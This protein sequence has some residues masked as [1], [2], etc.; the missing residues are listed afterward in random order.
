MN[1]KSQFII[2]LIFFIIFRKIYSVPEIDDN[3]KKQIY[4]FFMNNGLVEVLNDLDFTK[5]F[6]FQNL[7]DISKLERNMPNYN[8]TDCLNMIKENNN[9][10]K[11]LSDIYIIIIELNDQKYANGQFNLFTKPINTTIFKFFTKNFHIEGF[12]DYS[13][14]NNMEIKVSKKVETSKIDYQDIKDIEQKYNISV[15][16]NESNFIDYCSPLSINNKD[17]TVYDRQMLIFKNVKPCDDGCTFLNFNYTT[18]YST[19]LCKIYDEEKDINLLNGIYEK[20]KDNE[21]IQKL[22]QLLDKGNW[23]YFKCFKQAFKTNTKEKHNWIKYISYIPIIIVIILHILSVKKLF[24]DENN[25]SKKEETTNKNLINSSNN[26]NKV[27]TISINN[28]SDNSDRSETASANS[29]KTKLANLSIIDLSGD[30]NDDNEENNNN[31]NNNTTD[32]NINNN[33]NNINNNINKKKVK[34]SLIDAPTKTIR[35]LDSKSNFTKKKSSHNNFT[36]S[37]NIKNNN[38]DEKKKKSN[39]FHKIE[40]YKSNNNGT[41]KTNNKDLKEMCF[42]IIYI[43]TSINLKQDLLSLYSALIIYILSIH[44]FIFYNAFLFSDKTISARYYLKRKH[45]IKY[46]LI[47]EFDRI[48]LVFLICKIINKIFIFLLNASNESLSFVNKIENEMNYKNEQEIIIVN[49]KEITN[50]NIAEIR[51]KSPN[52]NE[53][54]EIINS[55]IKSYKFKIFAIQAFIIFIQII[56]AYFFMIFGN[57]NPNVQ[58]SLLWSSLTSFGV[59]ILFNLFFYGIKANVKECSIKENNYFLT[60]IYKLINEI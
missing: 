13:I 5:Y 60:C 47:N 34:L 12:L 25:K 44:N 24:F 17:L 55:L 2:C 50:D 48:L 6:Y 35:N 36:T 30:K 23:K 52:E 39:N 40:I 21:W 42:K 46:L 54:E 11:D 41:A 38:F 37:I 14:C 28:E 31:I 1:Y 32:N 29:N 26:I 27:Y 18:N 51:I 10:I 8:F 33:I 49:N 45:E 56:Y 58:L 16:K 3:D 59:Y 57:V 15:F 9:N 4:D 22:N 43:L 53:S 7:S 19:C 20:L